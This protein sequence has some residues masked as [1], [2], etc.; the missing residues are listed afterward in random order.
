MNKIPICNL[1][2]CHCWKPPSLQEASAVVWLMAGMNQLM[3]Q[4]QEATPRSCPK[5]VSKF[6]QGAP[7]RPCVVHVDC[8]CQVLRDVWQVGRYES[9]LVSRARS[10]T[11]GRDQR[12]KDPE[13][14]ARTSCVVVRASQ[15]LNSF[16]TFQPMCVQLTFTFLLM[17]ID[18]CV[19]ALQKY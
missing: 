12:D 19:R 7:N 1:V 18:P 17:Q 13:D 14:K 11:R 10:N 4:E 9:A 2:L 8:R 5:V 6:S 15:F 16:F 3:S